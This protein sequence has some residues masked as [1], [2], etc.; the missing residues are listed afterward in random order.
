MCPILLEYS[1]RLALYKTLSIVIC[2]I[3]PTPRYSYEWKFL[4]S[5]WRIATQNNGHEGNMS[6]AVFCQIEG[7]NRVSFPIWVSTWLG[8]I[9]VLS[10]NVV[11]PWVTPCCGIRNG[12]NGQ[13]TSQFY[14]FHTY[15][16]IYKNTN[17]LLITFVKL[18]KWVVERLQYT[19]LK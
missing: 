7:S 19:S 17:I 15:F 13:L 4:D 11:V 18:I 12:I 16:S 5:D 6:Y 14:I 2:Q 9:W 3:C 1:Q 8:V 10:S